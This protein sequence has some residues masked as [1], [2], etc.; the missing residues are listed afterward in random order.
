MGALI[1]V[2]C[3]LKVIK[4]FQFF[5][6]EGVVREV[7]WL[8]FDKISPLLALLDSLSL[9]VEEFEEHSSKRF[10]LVKGP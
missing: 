5:V 4:S 9:I 8:L 3:V 1:A 6:E 2:I 10:N 7:L